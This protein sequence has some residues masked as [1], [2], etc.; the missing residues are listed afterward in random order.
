MGPGVM[1]FNSSPSDLAK[2]NLRTRLWLTWIQETQ[3]LPS[4]IG[5]ETEI[6]DGEAMTR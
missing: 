6:K 1:C 5:D 4:F 3:H 2:S